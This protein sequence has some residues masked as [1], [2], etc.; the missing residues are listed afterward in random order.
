MTLPRYIGALFFTIMICSNADGQNKEI[1]SLFN[2]IKKD[3][4][5]CPRPCLRDTSKVKHLNDLAW[6]LKYRNV[7]TSIILSS[8][9]LQAAE[10]LVASPDEAIAK[11]GKKG[12]AISF[13]NL[14]SYNKQQADYAK[15]LDYYFKALKIK[16]E[17]GNKNGIAN[18][19]GNIGVVY[20]SQN[21]YS[22][23]LNYY[24]KAL[25]IQE[26]LG[27]K[28]SIAANLAN[29]GSVYNVQAD[30][31]SRQTG[32]HAANP[33]ELSLSFGLALNYYLKALKMAEEVGNKNF[34]AASLGNIGGLYTKTRKFAEAEK[35]LKQSLALCDSIKALNYTRDFEKSLSQLYETTGRTKL[36]FEHYK[37]YL[38]ARDS[39]NSEENQK[40]QARTEINH[41]FEK[42]EA[43]AKAEQDKKDLLAEE[44]K[45]KQKLFLWF[46]IGGLAVVVIVSIFIFRS[47][48]I[49]K[50]KNM[51][52]SEQ[53]T[54]VEHQKKIVE[55][56]Q[57]EI[58]DSI[59]YA[60]RIQTALLTSE[61]YINRNLNTLKK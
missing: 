3:K 7:D 42:K 26:E 25:K 9:A 43:L 11:A 29:I 2:L 21:D 61:K 20:S 52:I 1:D 16:E 13:A 35:Y 40:K 37:K 28:Q 23:A 51:T 33:T 60:K 18:T 48:Q 22:Q 50:K 59:H 34:I 47:L 24:F 14:G 44:E 57:K 31:S 32:P 17:L 49:N 53:K 55:E 30:L 4:E 12:M 41:E 58:L 46:T 10:K 5:A 8:Q 15:A 38:A 36:A 45:Q 39:I 54:L 19:L 6:Q 56:K 27:N